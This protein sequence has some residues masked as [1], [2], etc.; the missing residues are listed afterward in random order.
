MRLSSNTRHAL[1]VGK[2]WVEQRGFD[3][4]K[5]RQGRKERRG[6]EAA[7]ICLNQIA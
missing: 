2:A 6:K 1:K 4:E 5:T 7:I 3:D